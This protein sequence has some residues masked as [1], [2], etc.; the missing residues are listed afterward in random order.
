[1]HGALRWVRKSAFEEKG[2]RSLPGARAD[3]TAAPQLC[4]GHTALRMSS[5]EQELI[6]R[7][8]TL[9]SAISAHIPGSSSGLPVGLRGGLCNLSQ[10]SHRPGPPGSSWGWGYRILLPACG[11]EGR[12]LGSKLDAQS[13]AALQSM[14]HHLPGH[15]NTP[16]C[17]GRVLGFSYDAMLCLSLRGTAWVR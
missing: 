9:T 13:C 3:K 15:E 5:E 2:W 4:C 16:G 7:G 11:E 6:T 14:G 8:Q 17:G 1:M 12:V 10:P